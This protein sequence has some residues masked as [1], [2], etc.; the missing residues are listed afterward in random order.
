[1]IGLLESAGHLRR[2]HHGDGPFAHGLGDRGDID[3]LKISLCMRARGAWPVMQRIGIESAA[4][5]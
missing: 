5:E 4:A 2:F 1:V 3:S